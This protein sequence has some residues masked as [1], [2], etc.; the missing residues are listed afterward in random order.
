VTCGSSPA[1]S[2]LLTFVVRVGDRQCLVQDGDAFANLV[3]VDRA[4]W[5]DVRAVEV[6][7]G[8]Q[9]VLLAG[10]GEVE[11][12]LVV[13]ARGIERHEW[14]AG[15]TVAHELDSPEHA[16]TTDVADRRVLV[17]QLGEL[18]LDHGFADRTGVLDDLFFL[19]D[20]DR[21]DCR[22][23]GERVT[24]VGESP[25][26]HAVLEGVRNLLADDDATEWDITRVDALGEADEVGGDVPLVDGEPFTAAT[27]AG[28]DLVAHHDD[29]VAV[30]DLAHAL[31]VAVRWNEDAVRADDGL[32]ADHRHRVRT[33][34]HQHVFE[35]LQ[36]ALAFFGFI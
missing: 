18:G 23:T 28:H 19:E 31:Q 33:F 27:E 5:C 34:D 29:A 15:G 4:R 35:V 13:G 32:H 25:W 20:V 11:H 3:C 17:L 36:R 14:L 9:A 26:V 6:R 12:R 22:C 24:A 21:G 30:A 10:R 2:S 1:R 16:E 7:E 8:P